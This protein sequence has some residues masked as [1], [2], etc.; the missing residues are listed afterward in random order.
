MS[1]SVDGVDAK[2]FGR[3]RSAAETIPDIRQTVLKEGWLQKQSAHIGR[4]KP[5]WCVLTSDCLTTYKAQHQTSDK[6][7][8]PLLDCSEASKDASQVSGREY[9]VTFNVKGRRDY[10][11]LAATAQERDAWILQFNRVRAE[12]VHKH[13]QA[14]KVSQSMPPGME[15]SRTDPIPIVGRPSSFSGKTATSRLDA[16]LAPRGTPNTSFN[17]PEDPKVDEIIVAKSEVNLEKATDVI[18]PKRGSTRMPGGKAS[19]SDRKD[20]YERLQLDVVEF[21][22]IDRPPGADPKTPVMIFF[23]IAVR[24]LAGPPS[25]VH[26]VMKSFAD[27]QV[28]CRDLA[29]EFEKTLPTLPPA[30]RQ[31]APGRPL[32]EEARLPLNAFLSALASKRKVCA[33][34]HFRQFFRLTQD[35]S[36]SQ[37]PTLSSVSSDVGP[38]TG[39]SPISVAALPAPVVP[40]EIEARR[41]VETAS[42]AE[43]LSAAAARSPL[44]RNRRARVSTVVE[45]AEE[46]TEAA[47]E[48]EEET[49]DAQEPAVQAETLADLEPE[50]EPAEHGDLY[51]PEQ[52]WKSNSTLFATVSSIAMLGLLL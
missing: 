2:W 29:P 26:H 46:D 47:E 6:D 52:G 16:I 27:L 18:A 19:K 24:P 41:V 32:G 43:A 1:S 21:E 39:M 8:Y 51:V 40:S 50:H 44:A 4:W 42:A 33:S 22:A 10:L 20:A 7:P 5:R 31:P 49:H 48:E 15:L 13:S 9:G 36:P 17:S 3:R 25:E 35:F 30:P 12:A 23:K 45:A 37:S 11:L 38:G 34:D 28:L 14:S